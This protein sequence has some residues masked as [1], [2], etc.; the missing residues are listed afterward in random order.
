MPR[1]ETLEE[2]I[3]KL[4]KY[5]ARLEK[6]DI[7]MKPVRDARDALKKRVDAEKNRIRMQRYSEIAEISLELFGQDISAEDFREKLTRLLSDPRN[8]GFAEMLKHEQA[9]REKA[10]KK[11]PDAL[12]ASEEK[13]ENVPDH[14]SEV[15]PASDSG[16][17]KISPH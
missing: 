6:N 14:S 16:A 3:A 8:R 13:T 11:S 7:E 2:M 17:S 15:S 12:P 1:K 9:E 4:D 5:D 10:N